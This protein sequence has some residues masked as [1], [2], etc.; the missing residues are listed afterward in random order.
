MPSLERKTAC[1][2]RKPAAINRRTN[3]RGSAV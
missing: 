2:C 1:H 3:F